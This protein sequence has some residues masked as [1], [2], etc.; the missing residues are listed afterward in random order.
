MR[1]IAVI[2]NLS[3]DAIDGGPPRVGG[4][5]YHAARALR[6]LGGGSR[7]VARCAESDRRAL[8]G[9][10]AALGVPF[11]WLPAPSTT[12]FE[13]RYKGEEREMAI[14]D[15]WA[16]WT[17]ADARAVGRADWV[18]VGAL[19][20]ADFPPDVLGVLARDRRVA[21]DGQALV[22]PARTGELV[23]DA[24]FDPAVLRHVTALK[25]NEEEVQV[26]GGEERVIELGVPE[27]LL[28]QG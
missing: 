9:Q 10:L 19:T 1:G 2:G 17:L 28:T 8:V 23:L 18:Q 22:R 24:D 25:L 7:I 5:P 21:L 4:A 20:R 16:P 27:L 12:G 6:L 13:L 3:R 11:A 26:L 14:T 15:T